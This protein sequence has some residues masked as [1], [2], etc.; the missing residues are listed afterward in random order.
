MRK[1]QPQRG[2]EGGVSSL[3]F[4]AM[5]RPSE[6]QSPDDEDD[7]KR[8]RQREESLALFSSP[9]SV[10]SKLS[11]MIVSQLARRSVC[12]CSS[13]SALRRASTTITLQTL[14]LGT[15]PLHKTSSVQQT[16]Y[17]SNDQLQSNRAA[18]KT[19]PVDLKLLEYIERIGVGIPKRKPRKRPQRKQY[20]RKHDTTV[21]DTQEELDFF[22]QR[23]G[24]LKKERRAQKKR[25][26]SDSRA[27]VSPCLPP[28]PFASTPSHQGAHET[29]AEGY[30]VKQRPVKVIGWADV[31]GERFPKNKGLPEV[32]SLE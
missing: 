18:F 16:R 22:R 23:I 30:K 3:P 15:E 9:K 4:A 26:L 2:S 25:P 12:V 1:Q 5:M 20:S 7:D 24:N 28:P 32:V 31:L 19:M 14:C 10:K 27:A 13:K 29:S 17:L 11:T 21:L 8:S 6:H